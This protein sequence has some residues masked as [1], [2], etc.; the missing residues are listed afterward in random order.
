MR[1]LVHIKVAVYFAAT[2]AFV[3]WTLSQS[4]S[5][6]KTLTE[7][8]TVKGS[9]KSWL[10]LK[11]FF[12]G[13]ASCGTFISNASD[14]RRYAPKPS[15][16]IAGQLFSFPMSNFLVGV[17]GNLIAAASKG[18]F[19]EVIWNP[20]TTLDMLMQGDRHTSANRAGCALISFA[21][22]YSTVFS[23]IFENSIP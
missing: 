22:V 8:S 7:P 20:L 10:I 13:L 21:Y 17:F 12:L 16:V 9:Q 6:R 15:D 1:K 23:A 3:A 18:I 5:V 11:F 14:L 4:G 19:G 2:I